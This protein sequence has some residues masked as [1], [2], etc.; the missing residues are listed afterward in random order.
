MLTIQK[1][2]LDEKQWLLITPVVADNVKYLLQVTEQL[3]AMQRKDSVIQQDLVL[4]TQSLREQL[5][6]TQFECYSKVDQMVKKQDATKSTISNIYAL[7]NQIE[8]KINKME[9]DQIRN[10]DS[11]KAA[12]EL[13]QTQ[14]MNELQRIQEYKLQ[15]INESV[16]KQ[17]AKQNEVLKQFDQTIQAADI[18][19]NQLNRNIS[20]IEIRVNQQLADISEGLKQNHKETEQKMIHIN[21]GI[22]FLQRGAQSNDEVIGK[23]QNELA[24]HQSQLLNIKLMDEAQKT[25]AASMKAELFQL[26]SEYKEQNVL[27]TAKLQDVKDLIPVDPIQHLRQVT[28]P[29]V[30]KQELIKLSSL[31][32]MTKRILFERLL[33]ENILDEKLL[34]KALQNDPSK[35]R[36]YDKGLNKFQL[37]R[38]ILQVQDL[39]EESDQSVS[40]SDIPVPITTQEMNSP[41]IQFKDALKSNFKLAPLNEH[42]PPLASSGIE[43]QVSLPPATKG[44]EPVIKK[45]LQGIRQMGSKISMLMENQKNE[46]LDT[47]VQKINQ[48]MDTLNSEFEAKLLEIE[49]HMRTHTKNM[50]KQA[51]GTV[52]LGDM[53]NFD[54][55]IVTS[56][57]PLVN[58]QSTESL[59]PYKRKNPTP[60]GEYGKREAQQEN[61]NSNKDIM[62]NSKLFTE[63][64]STVTKN[65]SGLIDQKTAYLDRN[66]L[67][68]QEQIVKM[69]EQITKLDEKM[70][71]NQ[72]SLNQRPQTGKSKF[73]EKQTGHVNVLN[74][75]S[76]SVYVRPSGSVINYR[77]RDD[78]L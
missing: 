38:D 12:A 66:N 55:E 70:E 3:M 77:R 5:D 22:Q 24:N 10:F 4:H 32:Q 73:S 39:F 45:S 6:K 18:K 71:K 37:L 75:S 63:I 27:F 20:Q 78:V 67:D 36:K 43:S 44:D 33:T 57:T 53:L 64:S 51:M 31:D 35:K 56:A 48:K 76:G 74:T 30:L 26:R 19:M 23:L 7:M 41:M 54:P 60:T 8:D 47:E 59:E 68:L 42:G 15:Q 14:K 9:R 50:I 29:D 25:A 11:F 40:H 72:Q 2:A 16:N 61:A 69:G 17:F 62:K 28:D 21:T 65:V 34:N 13:L 58:F 49:Q 46:K 52:G 1:P